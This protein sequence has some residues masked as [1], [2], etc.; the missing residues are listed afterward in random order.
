MQ[1]KWKFQIN[2]T[3]LRFLND[4]LITREITNYKYP[5]YG[6]ML[7]RIVFFAVILVSRGISE[8]EIIK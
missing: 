8:L 4:I 6:H 3:F 7:S 2:F 1:R 5:F